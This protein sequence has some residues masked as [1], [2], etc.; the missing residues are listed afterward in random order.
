MT[1]QE[2]IQLQNQS[3]PLS[4]HPWHSHSHGWPRFWSD[5]QTYLEFWDEAGTP[6]K[7]SPQ[8]SLRKKAVR[9]G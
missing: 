7:N 1:P 6:I 2:R 3:H 9:T 8:K 4:Y 5:I